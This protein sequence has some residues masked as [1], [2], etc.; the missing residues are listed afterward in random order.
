[1]FGYADGRAWWQAGL[2]PNA[3]TASWGLPIWAICSLITGVTRRPGPW[4]QDTEHRCDDARRILDERLPHGDIGTGAYLQRR[5]DLSWSGG[6]RPAGSGRHPR[7]AV[8]AATVR[9]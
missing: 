2:M 8:A 5:D 1:M 7:T 9:T 4:T 6:R 3:R